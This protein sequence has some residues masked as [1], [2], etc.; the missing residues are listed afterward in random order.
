M[1]SPCSLNGLRWVT[2]ESPEVIGHVTQLDLRDNGLASLDL[3]PLGSLETLHCQRN[4]LQTLTLSGLGLRTLQAAS[5]RES[6]RA[7]ALSQVG[8][9]GP[10][11]RW[12]QWGSQPVGPVGPP[13]SGAS[14]A[15][16]QDS[17]AG[18]PD[19]ARFPAQSGNTAARGARG[20]VQWVLHG[21][22]LAYWLK[23]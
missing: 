7:G 8:P 15:P 14:G 18:L 6:S 10:P 11:A 3:S 19:W 12:G 9:V 20:R 23:S 13:A 21:A 16:S 1:L 2:S 17:Q 22:S 4:R 5:N